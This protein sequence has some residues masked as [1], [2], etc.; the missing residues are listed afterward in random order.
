MKNWDEQAQDSEEC[1]AAADYDDV[2]A[3]CDHL[4]IPYYTVN[5]T[6]EYW[7]RV[8]TIFLKEYQAGRTPTRMCCATGRSSLRRFWISVCRLGRNIWPPGT[9]AGFPV[10]TAECSC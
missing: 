1:T 8:F 6:E 3:V 2:R 9:T 5:F 7:Q 4:G 10:K